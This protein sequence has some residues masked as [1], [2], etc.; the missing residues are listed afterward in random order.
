MKLNKAGNSKKF[1]INYWKALK[2]LISQKWYFK[3]Q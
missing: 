3:I 2:M 1:K